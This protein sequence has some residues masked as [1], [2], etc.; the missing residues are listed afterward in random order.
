MSK[1]EKAKIRPVKVTKDFV[2]SKC[3]YFVDVQIWPIHSVMNPERWLSNFKKSEMDHAVHLLYSFMYY[4]EKLTNRMFVAAFEGLSRLLVR[5]DIALSGIRESWRSFVDNVFITHVTGETP[6]TTDSGLAFARKARQLLDIPEER[7]LSS[8]DALLLL[9]QP[10]PR[11][12]VFVDDFVGSGRQFLH[13]WERNFEKSGNLSFKKVASKSN[14][15]F[16]YCPLLCTEFGLKKIKSKCSRVLVNP[17]HILSAR[18][19][20]LAPDSIIW[21]PELQPSASEFIWKASKRAGVKGVNW[22]GYDDLGL[23]LAFHSGGF[24]VPDATLP[25]IYWSD[26][27]WKPL[28]N[29]S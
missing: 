9:S 4:D 6:S 15:K 28:I 14:H 29:K 12:I 11:S 1:A 19:N 26:N 7:V 27:G 20:A 22:K 23:T 24:T 21:P 25:I 13:T 3:N 16:Y 18:Y 17:A 5:D 10:E 2:L 8:E